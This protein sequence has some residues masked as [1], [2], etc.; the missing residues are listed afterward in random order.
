MSH[1]GLHSEVQ[2][3]TYLTGGLYSEVQVEHVWTC[4]GVNPVQRGWALPPLTDGKHSSRIHTTHFPT[5][6]GRSHVWGVGNTP[7]RYILSPPSSS[8]PYPTVP[9]GISC[10]LRYI[11]SPQVYPTPLDQEETWDQ[12]Y[13]STVNRQTSVKTLPSRNFVCGQ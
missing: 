1:V 3:W 11:L 13:P 5:I 9:S 4:P 2:L 10:P 8:I 12:I 7:H 6:C